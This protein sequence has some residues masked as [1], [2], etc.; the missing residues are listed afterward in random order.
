MLQFDISC[1]WQLWHHLKCIEAKFT[2]KTLQ[3]NWSYACVLNALNGVNDVSDY[4]GISSK[5]SLV[6]ILKSSPRRL[7]SNIEC[8]PLQ[9]NHLLDNLLSTEEIACWFRTPMFCRARRGLFWSIPYTHIIP[10]RAKALTG[11]IVLQKKSKTILK[12]EATRHYYMSQRRSSVR[13][14]ESSA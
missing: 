13:K 10:Y 1:F 2:L 5:L 9:S 14:S 8:Q 4:V 3:C 7:V 6:T 12:I 11:I